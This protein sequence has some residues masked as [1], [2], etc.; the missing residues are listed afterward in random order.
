MIITIANQKGGVA[1]T[2]TAVHLAHGLAI[3]GHQV[4]LVDLDP[5]GH[6]AVALG[7]DAASGVFDWIVREMPLRDVIRT[8]GREGLA[9]LPGDKKTASAMSYL[10]LEHRGAVPLDL[11]AGKLRPAL[12]TRRGASNGLDHVVVD[13]S[14]SASELQAAAIHAADL[15]LIPAACDFLS[16]D[17]V[18]KTLDTLALAGAGADVRVLPTFYDERTNE[19]KRVLGEYRDNLGD[20]VLAPVHVAT[21]FREAVAAGKTIFEVEP[22]GRAADEY[23]ALVWAVRDGR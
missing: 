20:R 17:G 3:Q 19:S 2:T 11:L 21:R 23:A 10:V 22:G 8:T 1:K 18:A 7:V 15:L 9:L 13:T 5:Q 16:E 14:P 6:L 4:L 12:R